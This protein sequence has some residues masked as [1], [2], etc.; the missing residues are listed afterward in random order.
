[1]RIPWELITRPT[2]LPSPVSKKL[3]I[4]ALSLVGGLVLGS[5]VSLIDDKKEYNFHKL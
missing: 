2:L 3:Q 1:M 5:G 4:L